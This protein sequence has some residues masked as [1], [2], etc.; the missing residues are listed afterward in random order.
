MNSKPYK[1]K[2]IVDWDRFRKEYPSEADQRKLK[3]IYWGMVSYID[4][5]LGKFM[6]TLTEQGLDENTIIVFTSDHGDDMGDHLMVRKGPHVYEPLTHIPQIMR[7][8]GTIEPKRTEAFTENIDMMPTLFD[9]AGIKLPEGV[10]GQSFS[11]VL[12]GDADRH[13]QR[14]F[15]EH[16]QPG[17]PVTPGTFTGE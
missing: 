3:S 17:E 12:L 16:G 10:Q 14:V 5:E 6:D 9:L 15:M 1:Q 4:D 7:W 2:C 11:S 13:R 8:K